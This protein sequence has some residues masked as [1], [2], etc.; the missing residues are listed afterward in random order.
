MDTVTI[1]TK[2]VASKAK[3]IRT[4]ATN[5][6]NAFENF[7]SAVNTLAQTF[8]GE[9]GINYIT[10]INNHKKSLESVIKQ[11]Q[12]TADAFQEIATSYENTVKANTIKSK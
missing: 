6:K 10:S 4:Q 9:D 1:D 7:Y 5:Y 8:T 12:S 3:S 11:L 2:S